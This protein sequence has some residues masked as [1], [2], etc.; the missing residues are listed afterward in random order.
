MEDVRAMA[1]AEERRSGAAGGVPLVTTCGRRI[2]VTCLRL[3]SAERPISRVALDV[4]PEQGGEP[5]VWA[6]LTAKEA[7]D[8]ASRLLSHAELA[9]SGTGS[10]P[11]RRPGCSDTE[12]PRTAG[13]PVRS[14]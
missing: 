2:E 7:R 9:E 1:T 5:G 11:E 12:D 4:G 13:S 10:A 3:A 6:A 8:L 14:G